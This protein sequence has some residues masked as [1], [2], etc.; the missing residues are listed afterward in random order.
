MESDM[1]TYVSD[2]GKDT[3]ANA[4]NKNDTSADIAADITVMDLDGDVLCVDEDT[5]ANVDTK[6]DANVDLMC[7]L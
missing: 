6:K 7:M 4:G 1:H 5:C 3:D 2:A